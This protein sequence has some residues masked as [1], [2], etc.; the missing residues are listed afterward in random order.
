ME[1]LPKNFN[2][3]SFLYRIHNFLILANP[4]GNLVYNMINSRFNNYL[5]QQKVHS[6]M[7]TDNISIYLKKFIFRKY[8]RVF[9]K[10]LNNI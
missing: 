3:N 10:I 1:K 4:N 5:V 2:E 8:I 6:V 7:S 9:V